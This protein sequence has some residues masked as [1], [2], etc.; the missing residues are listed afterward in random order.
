M[1]TDLL[2]KHYLDKKCNQ[3][4]S[5]LFESFLLTLLAVFLSQ[6]LYYKESGIV[7][8]FFLSIMLQQRMK[9][10]LEENRIGIYEKE[11]NPFRVN[12]K[13]SLQ[14]ITIFAGIFFAYFAMTMI[15]PKDL[16]SYL[17]QK[18]LSIAQI[19][20]CDVMKVSFGNFHNLV[21]HNLTILFL[22]I[23]FSFF[24]QHI[25]SLFVLGINASVW[26]AVL[27]IIGQNTAQQY[28]LSNV[29]FFIGASVSIL[30]HLI[31]E[32]GGY[33]IGSLGGIF[34]SIACM[35][36]EIGSTGFNRVVGASIRLS[37]IA[38]VI[39]FVAAYMEA[40]LPELIVGYLLS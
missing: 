2:I 6:L 20:V 38:V 25:G 9:D 16:N 11:L 15:L 5:I 32:A 7:S 12:S 29:V 30:P 31:F 17:F 34:I 28:F 36:Y 27:S 40:H 4:I 22:V 33:V 24:F 26:G 13:T 39:I 8:L 10:I 35:K 23:M 3:Y 18:Q 19:D 21:N 1:L 14:I 37:A